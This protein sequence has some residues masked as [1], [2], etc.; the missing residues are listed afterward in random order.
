MNKFILLA[1]FFTLTKVQGQGTAIQLIHQ[2][3]EIQQSGGNYVLTKTS[4]IGSDNPESRKVAEM[5]AQKMN[6]STG[7]SIKAQPNKT[8]AIQLDCK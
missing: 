4:T 1:L 7:F 2:P 5:L 3:I 6:V 8:G